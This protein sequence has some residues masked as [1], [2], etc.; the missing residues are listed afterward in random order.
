MQY[1]KVPQ[2]FWLF[3][4][5]CLFCTHPPTPGFLAR[6]H[7]P[8]STTVWVGFYIQTF[9]QTPH[10]TKPQE[11]WQACGCIH[12]A[13]YK[14]VLI[15]HP[16]ANPRLF[17]QTPHTTKPQEY[18]Q[19]C[20]CILLAVYKCVLILHPPA[21]PRLFGQTPHTTNHKSIGRLVAVYIWLFTNACLFYT[22]PPTPGFLARH[23]T[24]QT[25][26]VLAGL[27]LYTFGCLQMRAYFTPT[28]Q[29][30]AFW[31]DTTHH[32]PQEYWQACGCIL[33]AVYKCVLILHP[34]ANPRLFGQT[35][36]TTN[37][38][39]I[40]RLV[41]VYIWLFTNACLFYT[42]PPT[43]GFLARHHTPQTT[44]VLAGLWLYTFGCLQMRAYFTPTR[45]PQAFWP[46]T[47]HHK[48]QQYWQAC[49]CIQMRA[50]FT[51]ACQPQAFWPDTTH[52]G[53]LQCG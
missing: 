35:P 51:P 38:K 23:H 48:S 24:P 32:K 33:L 31:P 47:T 9:H 1:H 45:Q 18:W 4:N 11:Y 17:G 40:G 41:A 37:H 42:H 34:P 26:R 53:L 36:H 20:G 52:H 12:L 8:R 10:T 30:Q 2:A 25:T 49:G 44:R 21:N 39:S 46:D 29:P 22:H 43:P 5:A 19:A 6:H 50:Y 14:C 16:P 13:V 3:T 27:W 15:L 7:A 28:R